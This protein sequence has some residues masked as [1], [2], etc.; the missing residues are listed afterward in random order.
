MAEA[1]PLYRR[2]IGILLAV[3]N[4]MGRLHPNLEPAI[5]NY[6]GFLSETGKS[7]TEIQAEIEMLMRGEG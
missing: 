4:R 2:C 5:K 1:K 3:G 6:A 7:D